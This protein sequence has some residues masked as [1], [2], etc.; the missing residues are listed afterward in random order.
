MLRTIDADDIGRNGETRK[1]T[2][3]GEH[4]TRLTIIITITMQSPT[5]STSTLMTFLRKLTEDGEHGHA[6]V[7]ELGLAEPL[8]R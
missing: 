7:L 8:E 5:S 6:A 2:E 1:L 3:E 4:G